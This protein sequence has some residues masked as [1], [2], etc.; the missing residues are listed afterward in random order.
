[1]ESSF[2]WFYALCGW[3]LTE[4]LFVCYKLHAAHTLKSSALVM[5]TLYAA[6][7]CSIL[8]SLIL[9]WLTRHRFLLQQD[10]TL[11][12]I[13]T[14]HEASPCGIL[15]LLFLHFISLYF[16][17]SCICYFDISCGSNLEEYCFYCFYF[18]CDFI[19]WYN[20]FL[21]FHYMRSTPCRIFLLLF[22]YS[23]W[24]VPFRILPL[25]YLYCLWRTRYKISFLL[26]LHCIKLANY[27]ILIFEFHIA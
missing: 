19:L 3:C 11:H 2:C 15:F 23:T 12:Y 6:L 17:K 25:L 4:S 5:F 7:S 9:H 14:L 16:A 22:L 10:I 18:A 13:L 27:Q 26:F 8:L 1:M 20:H 21:F 24:L